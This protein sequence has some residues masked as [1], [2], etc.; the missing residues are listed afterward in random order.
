MQGP[1][2]QAGGRETNFQVLGEIS[3]GASGQRHPTQALQGG[4][5][6]PPQAGKSSPRL[7]SQKIPEAVWAQGGEV[8][9]HRGPAVSSPSASPPGTQTSSATEGSSCGQA[10]PSFPLWSMK[11][12]PHHP[13]PHVLGAWQGR[14]LFL[15]H[16]YQAPLLAKTA[17]PF[18]TAGCPHSC[19]AKASHHPNAQP[20]SVSS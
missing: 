12:A 7:A 19:P 1:G 14:G 8:E 18:S 5:E 10:A 4:R 20:L 9:R 3:H 17:N 15:P 2:K 13:T 11:I 16:P 6:A